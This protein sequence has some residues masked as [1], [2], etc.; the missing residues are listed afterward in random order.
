MLQIVYGVALTGSLVLL[1][2]LVSS[3][4]F[5]LLSCRYMVHLGW[6]IY[7]LIYFGVIYLT[8]TLLSLGSISYNFCSYF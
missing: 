7:A 1:L 4:S 3:H 8:Y 5:E 6:T 2:G